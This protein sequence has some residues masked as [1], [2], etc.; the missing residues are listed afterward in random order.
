MIAALV[1]RLGVRVGDDVRRQA[2][3]VLRVMDTK[4]PPGSLKKAEAARPAIAIECA[5]RQ[6]GGVVPPELA[7]CYGVPAAGKTHS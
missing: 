4:I 1:Q 3:E 2:E 6:C 5:F 7:K